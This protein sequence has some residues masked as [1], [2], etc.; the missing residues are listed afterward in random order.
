MSMLVR[1][2]DHGCLLMT[3]FEET[4]STPRLVAVCGSLADRMAQM[5][6]Y[7]SG[8]FVVHDCLLVDLAVRLRTDKQP[9]CRVKSALCSWLQMGMCWC[10][11]AEWN[12]LEGGG[13]R[14]I[15]D[16]P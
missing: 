10:A 5:N 8:P 1:C 15:R 12:K 3:E 11:H 7:D 9:R 13:R 4:S 6:N 2:V 16:V 14:L